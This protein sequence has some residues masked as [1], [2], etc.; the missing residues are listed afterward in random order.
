ME[1]I[2]K[3]INCGNPSFGGAMYG[4]PHC[5]N[6]MF[7]PFCCHSRFCPSCGAKYSNGRFT[8]M[9][10]KLIQCTHRH[11]VFAID[12]SLR[13]FFLED[14]SLLN[15]RFEAVSDVIKSYFF[16]LQSI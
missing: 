4:C 11:L 2:V 1:N 8:A 14:R 13:P 12:E 5:A 3:V 10:F 16:L 6:L 9:S 7:V 15:C